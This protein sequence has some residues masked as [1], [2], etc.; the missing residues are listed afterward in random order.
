LLAGSLLLPLLGLACESSERRICKKQIEQLI[1]YRASAMEAAFGD[2]FLLPEKIEVA[3]YS[4]E[5]AQYGH[6]QG[7]VG[8]D[9]EHRVIA[10]PVRLI[11]AKTPNPLRM[12]AYY[13]PY[14][15]DGTYRDEFKLIGAV[16]NALWT[17]YLQEAAQSH[18]LSWPHAGCLTTDLGKRLP[19]EMLTA[20]IVEHLIAVRVP[21][22]NENRLDLI[23]PEDFAG[24]QRTVWLQDAA[25]A[26]VRRYGGIL[27][28]KPL[29]AQFG[30]PRALAYVAQTPFEVRESSLR[31]AALRYQQ[32]ARR[33]LTAQVESAA[34]GEPVAAVFGNP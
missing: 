26:D 27:L 1:A 17:A 4:I 32:Q 33:V 23:W 16:D 5:D 19:C 9:A 21:L 12:A 25:Y 7:R 10:V 11:T 14:Y 2:L 31:V 22:F 34:Q 28:L 30:V 20:G 15:Q 6:F 13:W 8:Y 18:G 29:I 3:F 24:F